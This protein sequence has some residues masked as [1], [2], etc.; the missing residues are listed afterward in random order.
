LAIAGSLVA[1]LL[2]S[3]VA[4]FAQTFTIS[5]YAGGA[6]NFGIPA[7]SASLYGPQSAIAADSSGNVYFAD[8]NTVLRLDAISGLITL[9]A[10]D[11]TAGYSGDNGPAVSA[12]L[13]GTYGLAIDS[14]G[15]VYIG[16]LYD[17]VV[18]KVAGGVITTVAGTGVAGFS[19]DN[20]PAASAELNSP[21]ALAVDT[22]G[23]LYIADSGNGRI[24]EVSAGTITTIAGNGTPGFSGDG[25]PATAAQLNTPRG[26]TLDGNGNLYVADSGNNRI[27]KISGG[28]IATVAG[29]GVA[30]FSGDTAAAV[31]AQLN[32][33]C[34]V[35]LDNAGN[36]FIADYYNNRI[37]EVS[38]GIIATM[39]GKGTAG[40]SGD[41]GPAVN[42]QLNNPYTLATDFSGNLYIADFGND[43]IRK[44]ASGSI[45]TVAG[46]GATG[47]SGDGAPPTS[48]QLDYP[49]GVA[50]DSL[51]NV[52]TADSGNNRIRK[53]AGGVIQTV[54]G[55][56]TA[57]FG[58]DGGPA[59]S[60][61]LNQP[62]AVLPDASG[63]IY[64]ADTGN[65]RIRKISAAGAIAT[66]A[67]SGVAGF[68]GDNGKATSAE[69][70]QP[71]GIAFDP[72]GNLYVADT[73]NNR[74][75]KISA[76]GTITTV[77]GSGVAG[78]SGDGGSALTAQLDLPS[79]IAVDAT[80]NLYIADSGSN[81]VRKIASG[82]ITT[83]AGTGVAG[84]SGDGGAAANAQL[85][86]PAGVAVG[87]GGS[88]YVADTSNNFIRRITAGTISTIAGGGPSFGDNGPATS[89]ELG[90]PRGMAFDST[91]NLY[92]A[93]TQ[94]DRIRLL[95]PVPLVVSG[96]A[97][98]PA[99]TVG[100]AYAAISFTATGGS[101]GYTWSATGLPKGMAL[102][103]GGS[104]SGTPAATSST[105]PQFTVKD[106]S[107][108]TASAT[109]LLSI[110]EPVPTISSV[111]PTSVTAYGATFTLTV[112]G[113]NFLAGTTVEWN[114]TP[115]VTKFVSATQLTASVPS[116][117]IGGARSASITVNSGGS[118][119]TAFS[120]T[121]NPQPPTLT[122]ISPTSAPAT[123]AAVTVTLNGSGF[124]MNDTVTWAGS[125]LNTTYISP[126]QL[127]A[128][129]TSSLLAK[130]GTASVLVTAGA[131]STS[132]VTFTIT[133][134]PAI[135]TLSPAAVVTGGPAFT[136]TVTGTGFA[137]G[138]TVQWNGN[139]LAT[140]YVSATQLTASVP[141]GL[142][143]GPG[144]P[145][146]EVNLNGASS[147]GVTFAI[148]APPA[149]T[150]VSPT[151]ATAG[152]AA[153]TLTVTGTGFFSGMAVG[154][155]GTA[156]TTKFV[157]ATQ[158][159]A[160]VTA[161]LIASAGTANVTV[162]YGTAA[163]LSVPFTISAPLVVTTLNPAT[164]A[165]SGAAF[166]LTVTGTGFVT[167]AAVQW[168]TTALTTT[169]VSSTQLTAAVPANT[170]VGSGTA[171]IV[172]MNP[173][174]ALSTAVKLP[175]TAA[176]PVVTQNGVVP[177]GSTAT[178]I[179]PGS[180]VSI[181]GTGLAG[182]TSV[183]TGNYPTTLGGTSVTIDNK[184]AY[185]WFVSPTQIN[186]QAPI[187][188][189]T[190][191][192]NVVVKTATGSTTS[193]V[194]LAPYGPSFN[195][196]GSNYVAGV[197]LT[198]GGTG[199]YGGGSYDIVGP[200]GA[201][202]YKTRPVKAG[203]TVVLYGVGFGPTKPTV[204][205]GKAFIG[206]APTTN[207]VTVTIGGVSA[208]VQFAG[209]VGSGVYQLNVVVPTVGSG[210]QPIV[211]SVGGSQ[212][213]T[214]NLI[215]IQ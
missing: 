96:P 175:I 58:G 125:P 28:V 159:T 32:L 79:G 211:A 60:A 24:R 16:S 162:I 39:A 156:L 71:A 76:A 167:G 111:S 25:G 135:T 118:T 134:P 11:G 192:V 15:N 119:S 12:Q 194:T 179:Q 80:G 200:T 87:P 212:T 169:F 154:W 75:R 215:T 20:G 104:L 180:W 189:Q 170:A 182:A 45:T 139:P 63:N 110:S 203:E 77:A 35:A 92:V 62:G 23:N 66:F 36:L 177:I 84:F 38:G 114:F 199:A 151:S 89:A 193:T 49:R 149:V 8:G 3:T 10:G 54:A 13:N 83:F 57:G 27:R 188:T 129:V 178:V 176:P 174:G 46:D 172:V 59:T 93:D 128:F 4:A 102:S 100:V 146:V 185:L 86:A 206:S 64:V 61:Q 94:D 214:A 19:G 133:A 107:G 97:S 117:S 69:L 198:P 183:W 65:N 202:A 165:G 158:L 191:S 173:G 132:A 181:Y 210:D 164:V 53:I 196:L 14:S 155:N 168:N 208:Q 72:A 204:A 116:A 213:P 44:V 47:F 143:A 187:D 157:S 70:N 136:L 121:V 81:R 197:I 101:G 22:A 108:S 43:R 153:L 34:G 207:P 78:S 201:F 56:G 103:V 52:Y 166:T 91:G 120:F 51:G 142:V 144:T 67:G 152:G 145:T 141:P 163:T 109:L 190:G 85:F 137:Q 209:A 17:H 6:L 98:L 171:S 18:R 5:T 126:S 138:A 1:F 131:V 2:L 29:T 73:A 40:F 122:S 161:T 124:A 50:L 41:N 74:I 195:L 68:A 95:T 90:G 21:Y 160:S 42:A 37:R 205:A 140:T 55:N 148:N 186:L 113:T 130:A 105:S 88:I 112:N 30:G 48:A 115:L 26:L 33:P 9:V 106:S 150:T 82:T 123:S 147:N 184:P 127:T 7:T 99:G 31:G